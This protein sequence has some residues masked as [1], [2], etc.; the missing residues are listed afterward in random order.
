MV[1]PCCVTSPGGQVNMLTHMDDNFVSNGTVVLKNEAKGDVGE[2][3]SA[4]QELT[5]KL[6]ILN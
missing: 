5:P 4:R 6:K 2:A 3:Q 1:S